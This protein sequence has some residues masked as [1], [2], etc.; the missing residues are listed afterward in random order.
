MSEFVEANMHSKKK[1]N[2][3]RVICSSE[4]ANITLI[5][6]I[7]SLTV[8]ENIFIK[9]TGICHLISV[10]FKFEFTIPKL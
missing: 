6:L 5:K 1:C 3:N 10:H 7:E 9:M 4:E 8:Q 2:S